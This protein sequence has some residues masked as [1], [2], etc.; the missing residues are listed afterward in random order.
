MREQQRDLFGAQHDRQPLRRRDPGHAVA[1]ARP[2]ERDVEEEPQ[3]RAAEA[4]WCVSTVNT[5][6]SWAVRCTQV[7]TFDTNVPAIQPR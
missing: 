2:A 1:E 7:P 3:R 4:E 5:S 6:Q